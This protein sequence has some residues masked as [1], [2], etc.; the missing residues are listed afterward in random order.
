MFVRGKC[1]KTY[2]EACPHDEN[3]LDEAVRRIRVADHMLTMTYPLVKDP[4]LLIAVLS[5]LVKSME[6]SMEHVLTQENISHSNTPQ[7]RLTAYKQYIARKRSTPAETLRAYEEMSATL[8]EHEESPIA[9]RREEKF[10]ICNEGYKLRTLSP[11]TA[12]KY[13]A[14]AKIF[15]QVNI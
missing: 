1:A 13:V 2:I 12:K 3:M 6:S 15:Q 4:K 5:N 11:A 9:F 10:V 14:L 8:K 7:G